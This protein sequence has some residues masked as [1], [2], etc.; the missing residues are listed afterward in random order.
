MCIR[1][2]YRA[3]A[4][5]PKSLED[6]LAADNIF[7]S[8]ALRVSHEQ[9]AGVL[10]EH[11]VTKVAVVRLYISHLQRMI[12]H[13]P[14]ISLHDDWQTTTSIASGYASFSN[15]VA[16]DKPVYLFE[17]S[18]P[19]VE[20]LGWK[21]IDVAHRSGPI[22]GERYGNHDKWFCFGSPASE[23]GIWFDATLQS[24]ERYGFYGLPYLSKRLSRLFVFNSMQEIREAVAPW[25]Q[26]Q[27]LSLI[28]I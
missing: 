19:V 24:T 9:L 21:L 7:P 23:D 2:R 11:G 12:G 1:D 15:C 27:A 16:E 14:S 22:L 26:Q 8:G 3:L 10:E 20:S 6:I 17:V 4:L 18:A 5:T 28:H 25:V 13:D